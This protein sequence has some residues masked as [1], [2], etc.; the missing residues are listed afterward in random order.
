MGVEGVGVKGEGVGI[1][2]KKL[3]WGQLSHWFLAH[4][5]APET[6]SSYLIFG[7]TRR[8]L[9]EFILINRKIRKLFKFLFMIP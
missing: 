3:G 4:L 1:G 9:Q 5:R 8:V 7:L 2:G 6:P